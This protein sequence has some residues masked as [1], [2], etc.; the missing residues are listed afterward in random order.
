MSQETENIPASHQNILAHIVKQLVS[1]ADLTKT[2]IPAEFLE[3]RSLL[4]RLSDSLLH[5]DILCQYDFSHNNTQHPYNLHMFLL[6]YNRVNTSDDAETRFITLPK[7]YM[8]CCYAKPKGVKKPYNPVLGEVHRCT[9]G[10]TG[11]VSSVITYF[12]EQVSHHPPISA[13][14][15]E[16]D[17]SG[18]VFQSYFTPKSKFYG[19]AMAS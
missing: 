16:N 15:G 5:G 18:L 19:Y 4:E 10:N 1:G 12:A 6:Q 8:S 14:Y 13:M 7:W 11:D 9:F 3:P 17:A 2:L